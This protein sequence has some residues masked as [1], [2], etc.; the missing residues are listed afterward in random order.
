M[1]NIIYRHFSAK[2]TAKGITKQMS[3]RKPQLCGPK[4]RENRRENFD[5]DEN[6]IV[7]GFSTPLNCLC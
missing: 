7:S 1:C 6:K 4:K 5:E 2:A 3:P